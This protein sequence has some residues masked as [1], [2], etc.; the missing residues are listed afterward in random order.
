V[1]SAL[2]LAVGVLVAVGIVF[3]PSELIQFNSALLLR[4]SR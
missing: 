2:T 3:P 1:V 4:I